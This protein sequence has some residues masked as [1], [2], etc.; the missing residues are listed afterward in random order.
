MKR[1]SQ[2]FLKIG[3]ILGFVAFGV[4]LLLG[5]IY[6]AIGASVD[7]INESIENG[8]MESNL[9]PEVLQFLFLVLGGVF[10]TLS[11]F[12]LIENHLASISMTVPISGGII[13]ICIE[14]SAPS[15]TSF[16]LQSSIILTASISFVTSSAAKSGSFD[17]RMSTKPFS[18]FS[19]LFSI[20]R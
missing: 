17:S 6:I 11:V 8:S 3:S 12:S 15:F 18:V 20:P 13:G 1:V 10:I 19:G 9:E 4:I 14:T 7:F 16:G 5:I 2:I